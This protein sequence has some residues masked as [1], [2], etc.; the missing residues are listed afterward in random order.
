M[1]FLI[2]AEV[3]GAFHIESSF[4]TRLSAIYDIVTVLYVNFILAFVF[5][6]SLLTAEIFRMSRNYVENEL[7][8]YTI[9]YKYENYKYNL[10][11]ILCVKY[12][13]FYF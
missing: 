13:T 10:L 8:P 12:L 1:R 5:V 9:Y 2:L 7:K 4:W 11:Q 6:L 3:G